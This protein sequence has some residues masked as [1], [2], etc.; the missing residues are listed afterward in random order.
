MV[1]YGKGNPKNHGFDMI[2]WV[3][4]MSLMFLNRPSRGFVFVIKRACV[5]VFG[6]LKHHGIKRA[7]VQEF[8]NFA[9]HD[10]N[11]AW[12]QEFSSLTQYNVK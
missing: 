10:I 8:G 9:H 12:V 4:T 5:S 1:T 2:V 6:S 3:D 7:C 11:R